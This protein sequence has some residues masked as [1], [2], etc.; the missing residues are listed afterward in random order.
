MGNLVF[1]RGRGVGEADSRAGFLVKIFDQKPR[2]RD[3]RKPSP[4]RGFWPPRARK[5]FAAPHAIFARKS[6]R[7]SKSRA[8]ILR[9]QNRA[10]CGEFRARPRENFFAGAA[11]KNLP[12]ISRKISP[13]PPSLRDFCPLKAK[14]PER[15]RSR[16]ARPR[17]RLRRPSPN[18]IFG[19]G[20]FLVKSCQV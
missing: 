3:A 4:R 18:G 19:S 15:R 13:K 10:G 6:A 17:G 5:N 1:K 2:A 16:E 8:A 11:Y 20:G 9:L 7:F 14:N 12:K